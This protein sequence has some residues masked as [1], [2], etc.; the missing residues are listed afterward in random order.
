MAII[1]RPMR[2]HI[3][4][5]DATAQ[6]LAQLQALTGEDADTV[7][8]AALRARLAVVETDALRDAVRRGAEQADAGLFST[9][10]VDEI[11]AQGIAQAHPP[12]QG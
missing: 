6:R 8:D 9:R 10:S 11:F 2:R 3:D 4:I 1:V 7:L 5:L 12:R